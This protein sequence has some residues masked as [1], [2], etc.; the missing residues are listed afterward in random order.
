MTLP[1]IHDQL[2]QSLGHARYEKEASIW[3]KI[4]DAL[5]DS[6]KDAEQ[7]QMAFNTECQKY[8][9][10]AVHIECK[11][12]HNPI[13]FITQV[14]KPNLKCRWVCWYNSLGTAP[15]RQL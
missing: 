4:L 8:F 11:H 9:V 1:G 14:I 10:S 3:L 2:E 7:L 6:D 5:D 13:Y 12:T 15:T